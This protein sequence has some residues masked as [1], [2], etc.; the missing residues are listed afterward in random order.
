M[1][2]KFIDTQYEDL[3]EYVLENGQV[4]GDRT[5]TG[6]ISVFSPP[7]IQYDLAN[8]FPLI[9]TKKVHMKSIT[10]ELLWFLS[11]DTNVKYLQEN[12]VKIWNEWVKDESGELGP[13]YGAMWRAMPN[14]YF[15]MNE[16]EA[17]FKNGNEKPTIDQISDLMDSLKNNPESR[18]HMLTTYFPPA[19]PYQALPPCHSYGQFYVENDGRLSFQW[20][21]RSWDLLLGS[22][23]NLASYALMVHM[24]AQQ[25]GLE[26]GTLSAVAGDAHIY[27]NHVDQVKLQ[28]SR[29]DEAFVFPD[30]KI[31]RKPDSI[32]DYKYEDFEIVGYQSHDAIKAPIAV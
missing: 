3:L 26:V 32:F 23:F 19:A 15:Y 28:L 7:K 6:T 8:G 22:P 10:H 25:L 24:F 11:G 16:E 17:P 1:T 2:E 13:V 27:S 14:P 20:Y 12:G 4:R 18:R 9:T 31:L 21:Q 29:K 30:L 5:G